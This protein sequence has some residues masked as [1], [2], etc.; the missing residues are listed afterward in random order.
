M[1]IIY[2]L[3]KKIVQFVKIDPLD[4]RFEVE[5]KEDIVAKVIL[6]FSFVSSDIDLNSDRKTRLY[7]NLSP[8][9]GLSSHCIK[10]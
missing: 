10:V 3:E 7:T 4:L 5:S 6:L 8:C 2:L 1:D 9:S